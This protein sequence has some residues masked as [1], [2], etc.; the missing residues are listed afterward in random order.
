MISTCIFLKKRQL[1]SYLY[2]RFHKKTAGTNGTISTG[3]VD[4]WHGRA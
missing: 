2:R 3:R 1:K 4:L